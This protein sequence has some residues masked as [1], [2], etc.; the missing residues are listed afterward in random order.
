[1]SFIFTFVEFVDK[2]VVS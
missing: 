1:M 2:L